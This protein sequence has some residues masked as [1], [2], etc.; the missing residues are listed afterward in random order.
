M[1]KKIK[2]NICNLIK[3]TVGNK[4]NSIGIGFAELNKKCKENSFAKSTTINSSV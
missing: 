2:G 3:Q 4:M 1:P